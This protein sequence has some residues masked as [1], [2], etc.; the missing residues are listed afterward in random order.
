M[1]PAEP[2][3]TTITS[4]FSVHGATF[5]YHRS[6]AGLA[7]A[8]DC[9]ESTLVE[10]ARGRLVTPG[11]ESVAVS[12]VVR[13]LTAQNRGWRPVPDVPETARRARA[14]AA[15]EES[16]WPRK[17]FIDGEW[18]DST[19]TTAIDTIDPATAQVIDEVPTASRG[20]VDAAVAAARAALTDP[21][22]AGLL[23]VQRAGLLFRLAA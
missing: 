13:P 2:A 10:G 12:Q 1:E 18:V 3:P 21:A 6:R 23:P 4:A 8:H 5:W 22:W 9:A 20:D 14:R 7:E 15:Q 19:G 16:R 17:L 11:Q